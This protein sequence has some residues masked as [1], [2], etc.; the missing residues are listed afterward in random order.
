MTLALRDIICSF[1][2]QVLLGVIAVHMWV[3]KGS[4]RGKDF[5]PASDPKMPC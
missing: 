2:C 1:P 4:A 5:F 3:R